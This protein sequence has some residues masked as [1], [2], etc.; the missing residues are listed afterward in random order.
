M[1]FLSHSFHFQIKYHESQGAGAREGTNSVKHIAIMYPGVGGGSGKYLRNY[2]EV[3]TQGFFRNFNNFQG[4]FETLSK[5]KI[6][7]HD[8][9]FFR[10]Q[11][12]IK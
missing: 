11:N 4:C 6:R 1:R 12:S 2:P 7:A 10:G 9:I 3:H 5:T 8:A